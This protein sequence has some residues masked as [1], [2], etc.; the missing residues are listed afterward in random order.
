MK[1]E[2]REKVAV[3]ANAD[4]VESEAAGRRWE[5]RIF[6]MVRCYQ[7]YVDLNS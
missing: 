2:G 4:T 5:K 3:G 7:K 1:E 6:V